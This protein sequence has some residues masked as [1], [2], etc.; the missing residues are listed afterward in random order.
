MNVTFDSPRGPIAAAWE[1]VPGAEGH[2]GLHMRLSVP[3][4]VAAEVVS[5]CTGERVALAGATAVVEERRCWACGGA[6]QRECPPAAR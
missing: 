4:G 6:R 1:L 5:P 2:A 3:P